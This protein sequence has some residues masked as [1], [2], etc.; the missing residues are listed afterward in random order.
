MSTETVPSIVE[1]D[2]PIAFPPKQPIPCIKF[3]RKN[4]TRQSPGLIFTHGAGGTL[5]SNAVINFANGFAQI[6]PIICFKGN[7]NLKSRTKMFTAVH[8]DQQA[9]QHLGGRSMGARA[10]VMAATDQTTHLVLVSYPL[11]TDK[12]TR[13]QILLDLP[14][15]MKVIFVSGDGDNMCDLQRLRNVR[16]KIKCKSWLVVVEG[17]DH[18]MNVKPKA[19]AELV[20][21][22]TGECFFCPLVPLYWLAGTC[23]VCD[24]NFMRNR[25]NYDLPSKRTV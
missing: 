20:G 5:R 17:A 12:E 1:E 24:T 14:A 23:A 25:L 4:A 10:A 16:Q 11:H 2:E 18:G 8:E 22:K 21:R 7:M 3:I 13:D 9:P 19:G 6:S 15:A